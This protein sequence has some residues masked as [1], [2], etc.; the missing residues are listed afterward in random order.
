MLHQDCQSIVL[1]VTQALGILEHH[2]IVQSWEVA[3][4][5]AEAVK[6]QRPPGLPQL[7]CLGHGGTEQRQCCAK[8]CA[9]MRLLLTLLH[10]LRR[11]KTVSPFSTPS[12]KVLPLSSSCSK[13]CLA[14]PATAA[15]LRSVQ[16]CTKDLASR[17]LSGA[18]RRQS[19][20]SCG[21]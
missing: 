21:E 19:R 13:G 2:V 15:S 8:A 11:H 7:R 10:T 6:H 9:A 16:N 17:A 3:S 20:S 18:L 5:C 12:L 4:K 1:F 14:G